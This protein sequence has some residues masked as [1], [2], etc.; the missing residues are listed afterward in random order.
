MYRIYLFFITL[1]TLCSQSPQEVYSKSNSELR[2]GYNEEK[3]GRYQSAITHYKNYLTL[4][5]NHIRGLYRLAYVYN[6]LNDTKN[7]SYYL[8]KISEQNVSLGEKALK[9]FSSLP[10]ETLTYHLQTDR[11]ITNIKADIKNAFS[12]N[13]KEQ[14]IESVAYHKPNK[15]FFISSVSSKKIYSYKHGKW[16]VFSNPSDKLSGVFSLKVSPDQRFLWASISSISQAKDST[17]TYGLVKYDL[18]LRKRVETYLLKDSLEHVFGDFILSETGDVYIS[19]SKQNIIYQL[20]TSTKTISPF[21]KT[22]F[23]VSMQGLSFMNNEKDL[24][25]ADYTE[26]LFKLNLETKEIVKITSL[27]PLSLRGIDGIY[28]YKDSFILV[29]NGIYPNRVLQIS[30]KKHSIVASEIKAINHPMINDPTL[31]Q[32]V[33][34]SFYFIGNSQWAGFKENGDKNPRYTFQNPTILKCTL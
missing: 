11:A 16:S 33:D 2:K 3:A 13:E 28:P 26:G 7:V 17:N 18:K 27:Q 15:E 30:L 6:T 23:F 19:D 1:I 12:L 29:Q 5:P 32:V 14:L 24:L 20:K 21:F 22:P 31:G 10:E 25:V 4:R 8:T 9:R 34:N